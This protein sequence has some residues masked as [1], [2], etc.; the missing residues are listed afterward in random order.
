LAKG[1]LYGI[2]APPKSQW[3]NVSLT[4]GLYGITEG[5][6]FRMFV[7]G[8]HEVYLDHIIVKQLSPKQIKTAELA[9]NYRDLSID[10]GVVDNGTITHNRDPGALWHGPY[11]GL[12][13]G[14]YTARFFLR[15]DKPFNGSLIDL[16]VAINGGRNTLAKATLESSNFTEIGAWQPFE[17]RFSLLTDTYVEFRGLNARQGAPL[18]LLFIEVKPEV[19]R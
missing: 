2:N 16:D 4:Y 3:F 11:V 6:E 1:Y 7:W 9:F 15:L 14:N 13:K 5:V 8:S 10:N 19:N 12:L 18:S 17:L